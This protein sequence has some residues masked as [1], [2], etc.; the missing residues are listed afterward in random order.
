MGLV[1]R[2]DEC[3]KSY[4]T[5]EQLEKLRDNESI[6]LRCRALIEVDDWDELLATWEEVE[7]EEAEEDFD[8]VE[9]DVDVDAPKE[10]EIGRAHV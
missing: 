3:N 2:C 5:L 1:L 6:C 7:E 9:I 4:R 10:E 8:D